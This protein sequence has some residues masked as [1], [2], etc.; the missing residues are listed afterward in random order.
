M[1]QD[2]FVITVASE[3]MAILCLAT[4]IK[5]LQERLGKNYRCL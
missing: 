1:R 4:D 3:I 2:G 5:D